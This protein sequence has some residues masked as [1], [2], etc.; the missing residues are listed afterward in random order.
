MLPEDISHQ[1]TVSRDE[2]QDAIRQ[3]R[4]FQDLVDDPGACIEQ[5]PR[6]REWFLDC[7]NVVFNIQNSLYLET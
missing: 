6:A 4:L 7:L 3:P 1:W 2:V 5:C